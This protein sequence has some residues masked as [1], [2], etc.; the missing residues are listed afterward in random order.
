MRPGLA[1]DKKDPALSSGYLALNFT[2]LPW[3]SQGSAA[4]CGPPLPSG[5]TARPLRASELTVQHLRGHPVGVSHHRVALL[6]VVLA[7]G[8]FLGGGLLHWGPFPLLDYEP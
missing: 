2:G 7:Q 8:T 3:S 4:R 1:K 6:T 5:G